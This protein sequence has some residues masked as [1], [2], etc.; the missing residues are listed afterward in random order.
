MVS[1]VIEVPLH[2][3]NLCI[4]FLL[5]I[6]L[7]V[8]IGFWDDPDQKCHKSRYRLVGIL[9]EDASPYSLGRT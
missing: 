5:Y 6:L 7:S 3:M 2:I 1:V 9:S 4:I 8:S